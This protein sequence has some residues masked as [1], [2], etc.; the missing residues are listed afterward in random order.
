MLFK[1]LGDITA[2]HAFL[3]LA[4]WVALLAVCI[5][6][7]PKWE[8]VVQ[9]GEFAFL[10][11]DAPSRIATEGFREAFP[12]DLLAST[13]VLLVR[14][15]SSDGLLK[16]D[17]D[18]L[19]AR[20]IPEI[21]KIAQLPMPEDQ[22]AADAGVESST[23]SSNLPLASADKNSTPK[24]VQGITWFA[25]KK[26][27]DLLISEDK[28]ATTIVM[29]LSTEFLDQQNT[30]VVDQVEKFVEQ[31][32]RTPAGQETSLP[33]G[34]EISISGSA[35]FGRDMIR[36]AKNSA[37]ST[38]KWTV[39]LVVGLLIL[40]YRSPALA[41][42]PLITVAVSTAVSLTLLS[43]AA[44]AGIISLFNGIETYVT[45]LI[46]GAGVDYCLFLIA[47]YREEID[48]GQTIEDAISGTLH[49]I[50]AALTAS[51]GTVI[52]GIGMLIFAEFGKFRQA[53]LAIT[54]G[55]T[56][57]LLAALTLTPAI[58]RL[59][60]RWAFWPNVPSPASRRDASFPSSSDFVTRL[61]KKNL[62]TAGWHWIGNLIERRAWAAWIGSMAMMLPFTIVGI[63]YFGNLSYGLLSELPDTAASVYGA[64]AVQRHF[65]AGE[66]APLTVL[67]DAGSRE[68]RFR[69]QPVSESKDDDAWQ[70]VSL[71][72]GGDAFAIEGFS[73]VSGQSLEFVIPQKSAKYSGTVSAN[74]KSATGKWN[75]DDR[76]YDLTLVQNDGVWTG[77][78]S[79]P[80]VDFSPIQ[81]EPFEMVTQFTK[82][83]VDKK[84]EL[85]L[86]AVRS[87]Y[88][89]KGQRETGKMTLAVRQAAKKHARD[90]FVSSVNPAVTRVDLIFKQDP[91]SRDSISDF[92]NL[93]DKIHAHLPEGLKDA[94]LSFVGNT[95]DISDL[96]D[97]TDSDQIRIDTLVML[98]VYLILVVL[99]K[100]PGICGYLMFTVFYSYLATLGITYLAFWAM[101]PQGF[102]G[103]DW[104]VPM[105][106]FT[107][108]IAVGEDYNIFLMAR[109]EEEEKVHGPVKGIT[110]A[111]ERT[112]SIISSCGIIMAGTFSSL[113][114]GSLVGMDQ[115]GFALAL[116][117]MLDTFVIR[118]IMV[119]SLL[120]LL[121]TGKLGVFSRL[122][123]YEK[124]TD[125]VKSLAA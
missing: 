94:S 5:S 99:L 74:G 110:V 9:N 7:A 44:S 1:R 15:E 6:T 84:D 57:C 121:A 8:D 63:V 40:I 76:D 59:I 97:V 71:D 83:L 91:F 109:I 27:G 90:Y 17:Y 69:V 118:P 3:I 35:T 31:L 38:E 117:V 65:P 123:G 26:I 11:E 62:L 2:K 30:D 88:A 58:L 75:Q 86:H 87:M 85:G 21:H 25:D 56:V 124:K 72:E 66:V 73:P 52:C 107:I 37:K 12:N 100:R 20:V 18:Y 4:A 67:V 89:P 122:A 53:G 105:F 32:S 41:M 55:L 23:P 13:L 112:G 24:I 50:G 125:D 51:A 45:V 81:G 61:Q 54:F 39:I 104:K 80:V 19:T 49:R 96:K 108:L 33:A 78:L 95:A 68:F 70:V 82:N 60:G 47:R 103:L 46:Y 36:E 116:G 79:A 28:Q 64:E 92:R 114:A 93:R 34:L 98:G 102:A 42:I 101:D 111:L 10:P 43:I 115:L 119:P 29:G 106:L 48:G 14:R 77:S 22:L 120:M 16:S 113:M